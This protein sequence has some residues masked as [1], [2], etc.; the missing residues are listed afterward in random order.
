MH[1]QQLESRRLLAAAATTVTA[2]VFGDTLAIVGSGGD[3][4]I[5]FER[6][7]DGLA[8]HFE[9]DVAVI[10]PVPGPSPQ[11]VLELSA[12]ELRN[13][14]RVDVRVGEGD[15]TVILGRNL[16]LPARVDGGPG[17]D[18]IG[19]GNRGDLLFGGDGEDTVDGNA[20]VDT[21]YGNDGDDVL[22]SGPLPLRAGLNG[23]ELPP[24]PDVI[25]G[26]RGND[27]AG[28]DG[29]VFIGS[30]VEERRF[31]DRF[32]TGFSGVGR[33]EGEL[34][35][36]GRTG[37]DGQP[38]HSFV[39]RLLDDTGQPA[40]LP[41]ESTFK[42]PGI[43]RGT[44][45][46]D[47][48]IDGPDEPTVHIPLD[49]DFDGVILAQLMDGGVFAGGNIPIL[50]TVLPP[51]EQEPILTSDTRVD[52]DAQDI[53]R[54]IEIAETES[55]LIGALLIEEPDGLFPVA[56]GTPLGG[57]VY[58]LEYDL[59]PEADTPGNVIPRGEPAFA[60]LGPLPHA[61]QY[62]LI[63]RGPSGTEAEHV[64]VIDGRTP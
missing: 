32:D 48:L 34:I 52:P 8:I 62:R 50:Q 45:D 58:L 3:D 42:E 5:E 53:L 46:R 12:G 7:G 56:S 30:G 9:S 16:N 25:Y 44:I 13:V 37:A 15:D 21:I 28:L 29:S 57:G 26:G 1:V 6:R 39:W 4:L 60:E 59:V 14:K 64:F 61:G 2:E 10:L 20:G 31:S 24:S 22:Y 27:V 11:G 38:M 51:F 36:D 41:V 23:Q 54:F 19:G 63:V 35:Q 18:L 33:I 55:R 49:A 40:E 17:N 43:L 47:G